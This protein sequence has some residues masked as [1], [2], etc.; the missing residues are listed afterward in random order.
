MVEYRLTEHG[1]SL[2]K[3]IQELVTWGIHHREEIFDK[4]RKAAI[5]ESFAASPGCRSSSA[6]ETSSIG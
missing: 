4:M 6:E 2:E 5:N 3:M 1:T